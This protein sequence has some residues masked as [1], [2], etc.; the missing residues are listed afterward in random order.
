[1]NEHVHKKLCVK[2]QPLKDA[3]VI[4]NHSVNGCYRNSATSHWMSQIFCSHSVTRYRRKFLRHLSHL[5]QEF[6]DHLVPC[7]RRNSAIAQPLDVAA[8]EWLL[9]HKLSQKFCDQIVT[10]CRWNSVNTQ[11]L[12]VA[13]ILETLINWIQQ[14]SNLTKTSQ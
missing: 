11:P 5:W 3:E 13:E 4:C 1:M 8:T 10:G 2:S 6:C 14:F 7:C 12:D 9:N